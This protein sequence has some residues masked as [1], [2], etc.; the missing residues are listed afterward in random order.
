MST[1][2]N[3]TVFDGASTP[4]SHTLLAV[5]TKA[6]ELV[7]DQAFYRAGLTGVPI[8]ANV[9]VTLIRKKLKSGVIRS[10][11]R[12]EVPVMESISGQ[13]AAGYTAPPKVAFTD[14]CSI[15]SYSSPRSTVASKRLCRQLALNIAGNISTSVTPVTTGPGP[16]LLD[17]EI[18][19]S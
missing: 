16:E 19:P 15:V 14:S 9:R 13:N 8:G 10:E 2:A 1:Q 18:V 6:D 7:G 3:I 11:I 5:G 17:L 4:V 12:A